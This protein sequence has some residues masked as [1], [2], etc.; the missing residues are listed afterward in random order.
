MNRKD[1]VLDLE[2]GDVVTL[3]DKPCHP[4]EEPTP[5]GTVAQIRVDNGRKKF[6]VDG[7]WYHKGQVYFLPSAEVIEQ[8]KA[9]T[10]TGRMALTQ[11]EPTLD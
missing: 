4:S 1:L 2:I 10:V 11:R 5:L 7:H 9:Q 8:R 6:L 3:V